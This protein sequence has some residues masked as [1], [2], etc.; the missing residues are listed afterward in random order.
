[1][2]GNE[3]TVQPLSLRARG[4][5]VRA[6]ILAWFR[7]EGRS[8]PWRDLER[9]PEGHVTP[10]RAPYDPW[11]ILVSEVMLQQT[12]AS[13]VAEKIGSFIQRFPEPR[14]LAAAVSADVLIAWRGLGYNSRGLR[15][16]DA[17]HRIVDAFAGEVPST[18]AEL[19]SLPGIGD[20]TARAVLCF[21]FGQDITPLDVNIERVLSRIFYGPPG[22][23]QRA[24][25]NA[26]ELIAR[27]LNP[28]GQACR[29]S[30]ALMDFGAV[31][32]T[33]RTPACSRCPVESLCLGRYPIK[34]AFSP[35]R[36]KKDEPS[37]QGTPRRI[38]RG[39]IVEALRNC[40]NGL[41]VPVLCELVAG[42]GEKVDRAFLEHIRTIVN[43]LVDEGFLEPCDMASEPSRQTVSTRFRLARHRA[44]QPWRGHQ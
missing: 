4:E 1:M 31:V 16:R 6:N 22:L 28:K 27:E 10:R 13:R 40:S 7:E 2:H 42:G 25:R 33:A 24:T 44:T 8:F 41:S 17:A 19:R 11:L 5:S 26:I 30:Q 38:W 18:Y 9:S 34:S 35:G 43:A 3:S 20:Y 14:A 29:W 21:A 23:W 36:P 39:R 12:Q 37:V 32:C 15:L